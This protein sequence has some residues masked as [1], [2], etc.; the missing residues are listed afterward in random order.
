MNQRLLL[1]VSLVL[2]AQPLCR[3]QDSTPVTIGGVAY[4]I[5]D[6]GPPFT[7]KPKAKQ[8]WAPP[9]SSK[10]EQAAGMIAYVTPD[11]GDYKPTRIPKAEER[12]T[13]LS[14]FLTP[15]E[16]EPVCFGVYGLAELRQLS[17]QVKSG[18]APL[19]VDVRHEHFWP[20]R[21]GW[22]SR[23]WYVTPELLLPC[24]DGKKLVPGKRGVLFEQP[25]DLK[26]GESAAFWLTLHASGKARPGLYKATVTLNSAGRPSLKLP[27]QIE[28]LPIKLRRPSDRWW[29]LYADVSRWNAMSGEQV[30]A[31]LRD[32]TRHGMNG[33][34]EMPLGSPDLS[35]IKSGKVTFDGTPFRNMAVLCEKAGLNGPHVSCPGGMPERVRDALG[36]KCDVFK[37]QWPEELKKGVSAVAQAAVEATKSTQA[38]WY[39]YGWDEPSGS[40]TYA[41]QDYQAWRDGGAHTY[42]TF[43]D[44]GFLK[45]AAKF[46]TA[47]CFVT[48]LISN[49][50]TARSARET[51]EKEGA[52][53]WW[54]G[55]GSYV[56]PT[57][58]ESLMFY[59]RYGAGYLFWKS[60]AKAE[61]S[62]TFC[63]PHED[64]FNDFDGSQANSAEPKEQVTAYPRFLKPDG[65]STYQGA[66][67]TIAW[68]S[69]REG[70]DDYLYLHTLSSLIAEAKASKKPA[71]QAAAKTAQETLA[72]L[73]ETI[74][75][76]N[77]MVPAPESGKG[78]DATKMQQV[79]RTVAES[80]L[81]LQS[82][83][84][85]RPRKASATRSARVTVVVRTVA[86]DKAL[87][88][89][90]PV[91]LVE[92]ALSAPRMD[93]NLDDACWQRSA[94]ASHFRLTHLANPATMGTEARILYDDRSLYIAFSCEEPAMNHLVA[95]QRGHDQQGVWLD[96]GVEF[97]IANSRRDKYAHVIINTNAS[98]YDEVGQDPEWNPAIEVALQRGKGSWTVEFSLPW[99]ELEKAGLERSPMMAVNFCR[100]RFASGETDPHS[101][102][103]CTYGGFHAPDRFGVALLQEGPVSLV[104][105]QIPR[106]WGRQV[107]QANLRNMTAARLTAE[108]E[109]LGGKV[110]SLNL[111]AHGMRAV[112]IP[113]EL[114]EPGTTNA[115]FV[116]GVV[117]QPLRKAPLTI[118][119]PEPVS[120][121]ADGGFVSDGDTVELPIAVNTASQGKLYRIR[122]RCGN[123]TSAVEL[124]AK[125]GVVRRWTSRLSGKAT[126]VIALLQHNGV[127][128]W[129]PLSVNLFPM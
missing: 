97:F 71:V 45:V 101:A 53:F 95:D 125:P 37:D 75:W 128:A 120:L 26:S 109:L 22:R 52:E 23:E 86:P 87:S 110:Q 121:R 25:F 41:I 66:I 67:P 3:A 88:D 12:T 2:L 82:A 119:V 13:K 105:F 123:T 69:L 17:V 98:V 84:A 79:R 33:L 107:L 34:V 4:D 8:D 62:W 51:C 27:L 47:P 81:D 104:D 35:E 7:E 46:L 106:L 92:K 6:P 91:V 76:R 68:E 56:N 85:G 39:F 112:S 30:L 21:T 44:I 50:P 72:A 11:P 73:E 127:A 115:T 116:W 122:V 24:S 57:P 114:M 63:R 9:E 70:V 64:V 10:S 118:A 103:S 117:G 78:F 108:A 77:P 38:R 65:W 80:V 20:Q 28:I 31:E 14:A 93:G 15:G 42:A 5:V 59:N 16:E 129:K 102:W 29:L 58:Q 48:G 55:T 126:R 74:P 43:Y 49:E 113:I 111:P 124:A 60:G 96:D 99:T 1:T 89:S 32:F 54:Y 90:L 40:N 100:N 61:V 19:T 94:V 36:L 18:R 83:L